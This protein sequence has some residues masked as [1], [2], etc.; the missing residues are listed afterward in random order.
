MVFM[1]KGFA[2]WRGKFLKD[3]SR[4]ELYEAMDQFGKMEKKAREKNYEFEVNEMHLLA[5]R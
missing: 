1:D 4:E 3:M 2:M 5:R